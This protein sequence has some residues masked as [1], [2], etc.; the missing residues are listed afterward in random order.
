MTNRWTVK[1]DSEIATQVGLPQ[2][3]LQENSHDIRM[4]G[5]Q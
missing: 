4:D 1:I 5:L 3:K 2:K